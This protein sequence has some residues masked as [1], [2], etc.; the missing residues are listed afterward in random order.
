M[1]Q[2]QFKLIAD[3]HLRKKAQRLACFDALFGGLNNSQAERKHGCSAGS[4]RRSIDSV[5]KCYNLSKG[6]SNAKTVD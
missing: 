6:I 1:N 2:A 5:T 4:V 3:Q